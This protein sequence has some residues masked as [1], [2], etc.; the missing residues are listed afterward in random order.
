MV[1]VSEKL[2]LHPSVWNAIRY[3]GVPIISG[4]YIMGKKLRII[5]EKDDW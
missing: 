5:D 4:A 1:A 2:S 3:V